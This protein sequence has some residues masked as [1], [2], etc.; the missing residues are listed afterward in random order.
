MSLFLTK[1]ER[2]LINKCKKR[3]PFNRLFWALNSRAEERAASPGITKLTSTVDWWHLAAEFI[4]EGAMACALKP[5]ENLAAWVRDVTLSMVRR[6]L[7]DWIGPRFRNHDLNNPVGHLETAHLSWAIAVALDLCEDVFSEEERR[8]LRRA[9]IEKA[10]PLCRRWLEGRKTAMN[11][12]SVMTAGMAVAAAVINDKEHLALSVKYLNENLTLFQKDGSYCESLQYSNYTGYT[13]ML[14][15][16]ALTRRN[17]EL[18]SHITTPHYAKSINWATHSLFYIKP[19]DGWGSAPRPRSANFNDSSAIFGA[20]PDLL[21]HIAV[22]YADTMIDEAALSRW[23][24][25]RLYLK[26]LYAGPWDRNT[27]KFCSTTCFMT[28]PLLV[29]ACQG[30]SPEQLTMPSFQEFDCGD[31]ILRDSWQKPRT[32]LA[33]HGGAL[34]K[35]QAPGHHHA[36]LN[37]FILVHNN[38]RLLADPG[39]SCYR[40]LNHHQETGSTSHNT[41]EFLLRHNDIKANPDGL[42]PSNI[43]QQ[44]TASPKRRIIDGKASRPVDRGA[45]R[46]LSEQRDNI[47]VIGS[48]VSARYGAPITN[49]SRFWLMC[50]SHA[51]F[52]V[53]MIDSDLPVKT[54]WNWL[55]NNRDGELKYKVIQPDRLVARRG[56]AGM[57]LFSLEKNGI[58]GPDYSY[59][60]DAYHPLPD[61]LGE[62]HPGSGI[63]LRTTSKEYKNSHTAVHA[64]AV[65]DDGS[66][67]GWHMR[68]N[69]GLV[70]LEGQDQKYSLCIDKNTR[71]MTLTDSFDLSLII[72][73]SSDNSWEVGS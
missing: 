1:T 7:S 25:D 28:L 47:T 33:V 18:T 44:N 48:E 52:I 32:I 9:L 30:K 4:T 53:D 59:M 31:V 10:I 39:H 49:F 67:A 61:Q 3:A 62:G 15:I 19:M 29:Q 21:L 38:E 16:E 5:S 57:K 43:I 27:F 17:P 46:L 54:Q 13:L 69:D 6:P 22:R 35:Q 66:V 70:M 42:M 63:L 60:H 58:G 51:L 36:D 73:Q 11:W 41:C 64:I 24:F 14:T 55:L 40:N 72:R 34:E 23:M 12:Q 45:V 26:N 68:K 20:D 71:K 2:D 37:S 56:A 50:G 65:D 8:E